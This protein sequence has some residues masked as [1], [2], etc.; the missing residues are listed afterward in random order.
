MSPVD[1]IRAW[2][3]P[4]Y[5]RTLT[6]AER[7]MVP[8]HPAGLSELTD[9]ELAAVRG[10]WYLSVGV[11]SPPIKTTETVYCRR[12]TTDFICRTTKG[13]PECKTKP[14]PKAGSGFDFFNV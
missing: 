3:D 11:G 7:A 8:E 9:S 2:K 12:D 13:G 1:I 5:R 10:G 6:Q 4:E 14:R